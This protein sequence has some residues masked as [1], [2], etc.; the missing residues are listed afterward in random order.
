MMRAV[1][2]L[3]AWLP[4]TQTWLAGAIRHLP[5]AWSSTI[6]C[7]RQTTPMVEAP[8]TLLPLAPL[9][10]GRA[11]RVVDRVL[12]GLE[13]RRMARL[14]ARQQPDILHAHFGPAGWDARAAARVTGRPYVVSFYG[15]DVDAI[16]AGSGTW[17][18][19]YRRI[20]DDAA[21]VLALGPWMAGRLVEHGADPARIVV[22][23]LG[24]PIGDIPFTP[25]GRRGEGP[26]RVLIAS[27]FREK[28]G[29]PL[30]LEALARVR[31]RVPLSITLVGD[32]G[33]PERER[34]EK[35]RIF[36]TIARE[37]LQDTVRHLGYVDHPTLLGLAGEHDV[38]VAASRTA[39]DGDSEG[40][41]MTL[42]ELAATGMILVTTSHAD[43][44]EIV[45]D[46]T[47]GFVATPGDRDSFVAAIDRALERID[48][49][50]AIGRAARLHATEAFD[51]A[52]QGRRLAALYERVAR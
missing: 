21:L 37:G 10:G 47:T 12:P 33:A 8:G 52:T 32:A 46:G 26:L 20:F 48:D 25:R 43:I 45:D 40:T 39:S 9:V 13:P 6:V 3:D 27:S 49:W 11:G 19:R 22:H 17:R 18:T 29:I 36:E 35:A 31:R 1:H 2:V 14:V 42:A 30:A 51:A 5:P 15:L 7:R 28:K 23:H 38:L 41:P 4:L 44:P 34:Q 16:P 24:V 50:P